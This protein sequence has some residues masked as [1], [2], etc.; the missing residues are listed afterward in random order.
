ML[1]SSVERVKPK[2]PRDIEQS[3]QL[4]RKT[5]MALNESMVIPC[6]FKPTITPPPHQKLPTEARRIQT[7]SRQ[8]DTLKTRESSY[9]PALS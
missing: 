7:S 8:R 6:Q 5:V 4:L 3:A 9:T 2:V 1:S